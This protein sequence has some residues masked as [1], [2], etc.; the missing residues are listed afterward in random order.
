[1]STASLNE[2]QRESSD[3]NQYR[4]KRNM[5]ILV[6]SAIVDGEGGVGKGQPGRTD[7]DLIGRTWCHGFPWQT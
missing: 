5:Y 7:S 1:M 6:T 3:H 2:A 4:R